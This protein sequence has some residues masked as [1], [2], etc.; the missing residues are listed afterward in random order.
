MKKLVI[1]GSTGSQGGAVAEL[2]K[3]DGNFQLIGF[4]RNL[5]QPKVSELQSSGLS[6]IEGDLADLSSLKSVFNGA[7]CVFGITQPWNRNYT[8][9]DTKLELEQ[10]KN[11]VDACK[12]AGIKHL[13]FSSA[14]HGEEQKTGLPH[15]DVKIDIEAFI[16]DSGIDYTILNPV[17][18]MDNIGMKFLPIKKGKIRGFIDGDAKVPYIAVK[19]IG[20]FAR[21]AFDAPEKFKNVKLTLIGDIISGFEMAALLARLKNEKYTYKA[22]PRWLIKLFSSE[23]YK[24]RLTFEEAGRDEN[25][26]SQFKE[27]IVECQNINPDLMSMKDYLKYAGWA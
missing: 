6:M 22:V 11:I 12:Q 27:A 16:A 3:N 15:V 10:G 23:F 24:M 8:K 18:F 17:Q 1:C 7:D 20:R 26:I 19:D 25:T 13:V 9:V 14:A 5:N 21:L 4:S 2:M